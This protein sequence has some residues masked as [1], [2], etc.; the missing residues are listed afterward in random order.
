[1]FAHPNP[2]FELEDVFVHQKPGIF[3]LPSQLNILG[4]IP[5]SLV[6]NIPSLSTHL[7]F[8]ISSLLHPDGEDPFA[9]ILH[10]SLSSTSSSALVKLSPTWHGLIAVLE[11]KKSSCSFTLFLTF[12]GENC[13]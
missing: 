11:D 5:S 13:N 6:S 7:L 4:F 3:A 9:S 1:M 2:N 8:P 12:L 10:N